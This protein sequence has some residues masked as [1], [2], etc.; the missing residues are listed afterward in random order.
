MSAPTD[1]QREV[2]RLLL[3]KKG[4]LGIDEMAEMLGVSRTAVRQH[5]WTLERAGWLA[6]G[7]TR[8]TGGRPGQSYV[9]T[10]KGAET[11]PRQYSWF[12]SHLLA[13]LK[14]DRGTRGLVAALRAIAREVSSSLGVKV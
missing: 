6:P 3:G 12:S 1:S 5:L 4:G 11:F 7:E 13:V 14:R 2:L 10:A 8:S 9:L